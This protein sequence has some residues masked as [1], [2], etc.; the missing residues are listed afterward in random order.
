LS[1]DPRSVLYGD[2]GGP[3]ELDRMTEDF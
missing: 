3:Q 2:I 1:D